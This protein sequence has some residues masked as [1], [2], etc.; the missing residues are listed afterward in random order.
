MADQTKGDAKGDAK[1]PFAA[2]DAPEGASAEELAEVQFACI[3]SGCLMLSNDDMREAFNLADADGN[4][5]ISPEE[6]KKVVQKLS[7]DEETLSD[8][9]VGEIFALVDRNND[10]QIDFEEFVQAITSEKA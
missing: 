4:G 3:G 2:A 1:A 10:G 8:A 6:L 7:D 9:E 5:T